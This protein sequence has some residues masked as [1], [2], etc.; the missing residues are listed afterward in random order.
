MFTIGYVLR[1]NMEMLD[2]FCCNTFDQQYQLFCV[3][4]CVL[5]NLIERVTEVKKGPCQ[6]IDG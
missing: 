5:E 3:G 6:G 2:L 1:W 4:V